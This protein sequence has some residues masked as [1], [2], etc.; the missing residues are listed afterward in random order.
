MKNKFI[1]YMNIS[2]VV[3]V[4]TFCA[5]AGAFAGIRQMQGCSYNQYLEGVSN[6]YQIASSSQIRFIY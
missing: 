6:Y 4:L 3:I 5:H 2:I 1:N